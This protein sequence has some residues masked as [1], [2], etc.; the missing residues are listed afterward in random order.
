MLE[1]RRIDK[2]FGANEIYR[3]LCLQVWR[4]ETLTI[5]GGSGEGKSVLLKCLLGLL[6]VD[7]G[8]IWAFGGRVDH[9]DEHGYMPVRQRV[10]M[11]FQGAA[12][13]DSLT[14]AGNIAYPLVEH[15]W[16]D[17]SAISDRVSE[18]LEMV[19][20]P[21]IEEMRPADLSGGMKKRVGLARA[22]AIEPE[23]IQQIMRA[24]FQGKRN[25]P[26]VPLVKTDGDEF[27]VVVPA[28]V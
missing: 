15:G 7:A 1:F 19:G 8:E 25:E 4:G 18:T 27:S 11:L 13:F 26:L 2:S 20:L 16:A 14:V 24:A 23:V 22:I 6:R 3:N 28:F 21:G 9:L 10:G 5:L 12:L 17:R